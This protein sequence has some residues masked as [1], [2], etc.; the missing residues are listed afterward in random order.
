M[1]GL[2]EGNHALAVEIAALPDMIRGYENIK[3][4]NVRAYRERLTELRA[5]FGRSTSGTLVA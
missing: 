4:A 2:T 5:E 3:L 1:A